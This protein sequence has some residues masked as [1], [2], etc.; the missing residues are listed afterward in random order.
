MPLIPAL[1]RQRQADLWVQ[2]QSGLQSE[3]QDSQGY[4]EKPWLEKQKQKQ[5]KQKPSVHLWSKEGVSVSVSV[6]V[7]V[8][9]S[10]YSYYA[11]WIEPGVQWLFSDNLLGHT[12]SEL[13]TGDQEI[14]CAIET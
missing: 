2:C 4:T 11:G 12:N 3:F 14:S 5:K 10:T 1:R 8:P 7:S 13:V 9:L 6:S